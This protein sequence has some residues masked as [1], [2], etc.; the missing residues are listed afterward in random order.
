MTAVGDVVRSVR[1]T[2][3]V[4]VA[5]VGGWTDTWFAGRGAVCSLGVGPGIT[6]HADLLDGP[7]PTRP[8]RIVADDLGEDYRCGPDTVHGWTRPVPGRH[9][10][11]EHAVAAVL[12]GREPTGPI[13]LR[14]RSA[15][16]PG[17]SLGTSASVVVA[18]LAALDALVDAPEE[19]RDDAYR[20]HLA[21]RAHRVETDRAGRE[22]GIQDQWAAAFGG[23]QLLEMPAYPE[24][25]RR[26]VRLSADTRGRLDD[27]LVTVGVGRHDSSA[28]HRSVIDALG[29]TGAVAS[30]GR[31][32]LGDLTGLAHTAA[33]ALADGDLDEWAT[34]LTRCTDAQIRLHPALAGPGHRAVIA[35]AR[36]HGA[37][38]WKI[39][40]AGG[41]GGSVTVVFENRDH[42]AGFAAHIASEG[43]AWAV[44]P[45]TPRGGVRITPPG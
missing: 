27:T 36:D 43:P 29:S 15:V 1:V 41:A 39:N 28:V 17:A 11:L 5:D 7:S 18:L 44:L 31:R 10:L 12:E 45:L 4:R 9:P 42:A 20:G 37:A 32:V 35:R 21:V 38:G 22:S 40:G 16:P 34:T 23:A 24:V 33:D 2:T 13:R 26:P 14:V 25:E 6:V 30:S 19:P 8:V 3:P